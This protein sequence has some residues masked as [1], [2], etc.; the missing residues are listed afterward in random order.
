M[1]SR[2][3]LLTVL[4]IAFLPSHIFSQRTVHF[5]A[6]HA[7]AAMALE[8][9]S[10]RIVNLTNNRAH[11]LIGTASYD[12]DLLTGVSDPPQPTGFSL[13][14]NYPNAFSDIT[15]FN[16]QLPHAQSLL[17]QVFDLH[18]RRLAWHSTALEPG[19]HKFSFNGAGLAHGVYI[20]TAANGSMMQARKLLKLAG[21][22]SGVPTF[23][24]LEQA[25][26]GSFGKTATD[27]YRFTA[28]AEAFNAEVID[29][30]SPQPEQTFSFDLT[31]SSKPHIE[32][33]TLS[34]LSG[35]EYSWTIQSD[36]L[37]AQA[38]Y[39][40]HFGD[41]E[42]QTINNNTNATHS[43]TAEGNF[44]LRVSIYNLRNNNFI[45]EAG[46][47]VEI[48]P[49][50]YT[51]RVTP[52][53]LSGIT[54]AAYTW[55]AVVTPLPAN[56][57]YEWVF[58]DGGQLTRTNTGQASHTY[59]NPGDYRVTLDVYDTDAGNRRIGGDTV[60]A[61]ISAAGRIITGDPVEAAR[62]PIGT[63]GG[64]IEVTQA[65]TP[66][67]GLSILVD[68][69]GYAETREFV[70]SYAPVISHGMGEHFLPLSPLITVENGGGYAENPMILC[71]PIT[72]PDDHFAMAFFYDDD[73]GE[74]EGLPIIS[75]DR[76]RI[77]VATRH[78]S[79]D[80]M[81]LGKR[82]ARSTQGTYV[83][84][85]VT[86]V[87]TD[88][89]SGNVT[90]DFRPGVDDWEFPNYGS[91]ISPGGH[92]AGQTIS[93]MWYYTAQKLTRGMPPLN[94][95]FDQVHTD[96][97]WMD[98]PDGYRLCSVVQE[99]LSVNWNAANQWWMH[100][101]TLGTKVY[102]RDSLNFLA[103]KYAVL[104]T[105]KPQF[106]C[107]SRVISAHALTLLGGL[108]DTLMV[109]D[110]NYP[111]IARQISLHNGSL[112]PYRTMQRVGA[113]VLEYPFIYYY[114]KTSMISYQEVADRWSQFEQGTIGTVP[115]HLFPEVELFQLIVE[116]GEEEDELPLTEVIRTSLDTLSIIA[117]CPTCAATWP[118]QRTPIACYYEQGQFLTSA[119]RNDG[120]LRIPL[121]PGT[122]RYGLRIDGFHSG[123]TNHAPRYITFVWLEV[124]KVSAGNIVWGVRAKCEDDDDWAM[125]GMMDEGMD[126]LGH[127]E[128]DT[129][130]YL[131][132]QTYEG[133]THEEN[134]SAVIDTLTGALIS[135]SC[136]YTITPP[137]L[138]W[139]MLMQIEGRN[140]PTY[141]LDPDYYHY[142]S[143]G[144]E[145]C[146][147]IDDV[148]GRNVIMCGN[149]EMW[150]C[151]D[152]GFS[153]DP[154]HVYITLP[155]RKE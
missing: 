41:G 30:V 32:P 95:R 14:M 12:L 15:S 42:T 68:E 46:A 11:T 48:L 4:L 71:I 142:R 3:I 33:A 78:F 112:E 96:S 66:V 88:E 130:V 20:L 134:F 108:G 135:Y 121:Q 115:P 147:Y 67:T 9:D 92:C 69:Q 101:D 104:M 120:V 122:H 132:T 93:A 155:A 105:R 148:Q 74:L 16:V 59:D 26:T 1:N 52:E 34:G 76:D 25:A 57:R 146:D 47:S 44:E 94:S 38:R 139:A 137:D 119:D 140:L 87:A 63:G 36:A 85:I 2:L 56:V 21:S 84:L 83:Q 80:A 73:T 110:P 37:P 123:D 150:D 77:C 99:D 109:A 51:V 154:T 91:Y 62:G 27:F 102:S 75:L 131:R 138:E 22:T 82:G 81:R 53:E 70:I 8:L 28:Y 5:E 133:Y 58:G 98:N 31:P 10:V 129:Y 17:L 144:P 118:Q 90:T 6:L 128:G 141:S 114:A 64:T 153:A 50:S 35:T 125:I 19:L 127:W 24:Y 39:I 23:S 149:L 151:E 7:D 124:E 113:P 100:F 79:S 126:L 145:T 43:Y 61:L 60:R 54:G 45:S 29:N 103:F 86:A 18:G 49:S 55:N 106:V 143:E 111:G 65:G 117:R 40:W 13:S 152:H 97:M 116:E 107:V 72:L 89:L 136:S